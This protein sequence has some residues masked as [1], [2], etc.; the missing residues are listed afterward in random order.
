MKELRIGMIGLDTSHCGAF[1]KTLNDKD[2]PHHVP[3]GKVVA[4]VPAGNP[5]LP[6]SR[7]RI[8]GFTKELVDTFGLKLCDSIPE[9]LEQVDAIL[10]HSVDGGQHAEQFARI[11]PSGK[12]VFIDKPLA[13]SA[14]DARKIAELSAGHGSPVMSCSALRYAAGISDLRGGGGGGS[15][16]KVLMCDACGPMPYQV[17]YPGLFWYGVHSA[18]LLFSFMGKGCQSVQAVGNDRMDVVVGIWSDGRIGSVRGWRDGPST[19]S[20]TVADEKNVRCS[21]A[22]RDPPY[23][24]LLIKDVIEFFNTRKPPIDI[25][26]TVEIT[27]FL[28]AGNKSKE[29]N[30]KSVPL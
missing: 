18:E 21:P 11:A 26:E 7:D 25:E 22:L 2:S 17:G 27:A 8:E 6:V 10:L 14:A 12:C 13:C 5:D 16:Q 28:E 19:F 29:L 9:L 3:G 1:A 4:A 23:T 15:G 24:A 30:G 20:C